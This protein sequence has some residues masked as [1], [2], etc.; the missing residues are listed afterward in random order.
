M[1]WQHG[2]HTDSPYTCGYYRELAPAWLDFASLLQGQLPPRSRQGEPFSYLELGSGMGLGLCLLAATHPEGKF[3]GIDFKP[4]HILHSRRLARDLELE[5]VRFIEADFLTLADD[6]GDLQDRH[7]YVVAH[8][9]AT[10]ITAPI[11]KALLSVAAAAL[12]PGGLFYCSYNTFPGWL[13]AVPVQKLAWH[14]AG[15]GLPAPEALRQTASKLTALLGTEQAPSALAMTLPTLRGRVSQMANLDSTYLCQEYINGG[16]QPLMVTEMHER[17]AE[18]KLSFVA[19]ATLPENFIGLLPDIVRATVAEETD[20]TRR[21]LLQDIAVNQSFRRDVMVRGRLGTR[22]QELWAA[23]HA[24]T[25]RLQEAPPLEIY[26]FDTT[27]GVVTC[28]ADNCRAV[29]QALAAGPRRFID[30]CVEL[31]ISQEALAELVAL[32]L[33]ANRIGL[34]RGN[35]GKAA[36][37]RVRKVNSTLRAMQLQGRSYAYLASASIGSAVSFSHV[38]NLLLEQTE[39]DQLEQKLLAFGFRLKEQPA[40]LAENFENRRPRLAALGVL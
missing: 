27:I 23:I 16:W 25:F 6:L 18:F 15:S 21:L 38:E 7:Q 37:N 5:N 39:H 8:G 26:R 34:D 3:T 11:Q 36:S 1:T 30:L 40:T 29:E 31:N 17:A 14:L 10:W 9:I 19:S 22:M 4:D 32:L 20:P 28:N 12:Q 35:A 13:N 2:Y 33:H 24:T